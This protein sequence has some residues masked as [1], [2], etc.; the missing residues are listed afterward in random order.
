MTETRHVLVIDDEVEVT[1]FFTY[2]L[3]G[4]NCEVRIANSGREVQAILSDPA[5]LFHLALVDLKLPDANGLEL[6]TLLK[7]RYPACEV[8]IMT[9]YSTIQSAITAI[10]NGAKDYLEKPF[11]DLEALENVLN[12]ILDSFTTHDPQDLSYHALQYGITYSTSSPLA[13]LMSI[14]YKLA[15]KNINVLIQGETGTGKELMA[16]F[17][18]GTSMRS[19]GPFIGINCGA[20]P[21]SLM[22]SEL[23]GHEKGAFT[24]AVK[25]RKGFFELAHQG[26]LFLDEI[27]ESPFPIQVKLLRAMETGEFMRVGS[28]TPITSNIRFIAATNRNLEEE[29]EKHRFRS[30]LLYRLEGVKLHL[31]PLRERA[32]DIPL[33][34]RH[35][36]EKKYE[37][38]IEIDS[39]ALHVLKTYAWPGNIRQL[40]N[41]L[42]Q[43]IAIHDC[44]TIRSDFLPTMLWE[45]ENSSPNI[46]SVL[47]EDGINGEIDQFIENFVQRL[48]SIDELDY[49][50][51][52]KK[53]K[54]IEIEVGRKIIQKGLLETNG[55]RKLLSQKLNLT[56]RVIR[57]V[58]SEKN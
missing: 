28:E 19:Q 20:I 51:V 24:H 46:P 54:K 45:K 53:I 11:D 55:N 12:P 18:H 38:R 35:Y 48:P 39:S 58:L 27:G 30:D 1:S 37:G 25:T 9:G 49:Q 23:F 29:V 52:M 34:C 4:K 13:N 44:K 21:D 57:Y 42:N 10:Q 3:E 41:I 43:T 5:T 16:R 47:L 26:T 50:E 14:A 31:P 32:E 56:N 6:L 33:I 22:E 7:E 40:I 36:L 15:K 2:L 8:I 17:I